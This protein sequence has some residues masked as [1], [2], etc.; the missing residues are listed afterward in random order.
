MKHKKYKESE[1]EDPWVLV[2]AQNLI[3]FPKPFKFDTRKEAH[4]QAQKIYRQLGALPKVCKLS[5][6]KS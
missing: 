1:L 6:L 5:E 3:G 4:A 2:Y